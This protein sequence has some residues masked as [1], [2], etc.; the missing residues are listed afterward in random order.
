LSP[1]D[2][3]EILALPVSLSPAK[4]TNHL[5]LHMSSELSQDLNIFFRNVDEKMRIISYFKDG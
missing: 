5:K 4:H 1:Y 3:T 2:N